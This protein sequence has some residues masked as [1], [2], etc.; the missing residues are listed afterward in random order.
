MQITPAAAR[1]DAPTTPATPRQEAAKALV[2]IPGAIA[3]MASF[4]AMGRTT[5]GQTASRA[6]LV[7]PILEKLSPEQAAGMMLQ[8]IDGAL[9]LEPALATQADALRQAAAGVQALLVDA[10]ADTAQ[11]DPQAALGALMTPMQA[12][13][14]PVVQAAVV[15]D[16]E[17][18]KD[19]PQG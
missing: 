19:A 16:P 18:G 1:T 7:A 4:T 17:F 13:L 15:L 14:A 11:V 10:A 2:A 12:L 8:A 5:A 6:D 9:A 3:A